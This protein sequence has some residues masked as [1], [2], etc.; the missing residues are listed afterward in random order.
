MRPALALAATALALAG[1]GGPGTH[2]DV[3]PGGSPTRGHDLIVYYGCGACHVIGGVGR[4]NGHVG[5][6]LTHFSAK[7]TIAGKLAN[8]PAQVER[9]IA[10]PQKVVPGNDMPVLGV[11]ADQLPDIV[12]YLYTQ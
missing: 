6:P 12:A 2:S 3:V 7:D 11:H 10:N 8:T 1:C 9:W 4:A 5:P